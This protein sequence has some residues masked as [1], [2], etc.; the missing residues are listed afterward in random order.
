[1]KEIVYMPLEHIEQRY[2]THLDNDI[3]NYLS[4][5]HINW[6]YLHPR[7]LGEDQY[8]TIKNGNFLNANDTIYRQFSQFQQLIQGLMLG[9]ISKDAT[10]FITDIWNFGIMAIPY[11]NFF[12]EYDLKVKGV[13]HAGSFTDTDFVRQMERYYKNF[14]DIIFD[15]CDTI[16]V[17]SEFIKQDII[18]KRVID[19]DKLVVTGLPL[20]ENKY[21]RYNSPIKHDNIIFNGRNCDEKQPWLF[22]RLQEKLPNYNFF[23]TQKMNLKKH[24]YYTL[25]N[26]SKAV[27]SF[28]LQENFG[29]GIQEAVQLGCIPIV[30]NRLVYPE[31]FNHLY[32]YD[33]FDECVKKVDQAIKGVLSVP[34][35]KN[36]TNK[37]IFKIWFNDND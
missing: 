25:L 3:C 11:L 35:L 27:V 16:Y 34:K 6:K 10:I 13:L 19:A 36:K 33:N 5:N 1:M 22:D 23:N 26:S 32:L 30:P 12:S 29:Y 28:A 2:T 15:I 24:Q 17:G 4:V 20:D 37:E 8:G 14:E 18:R 9:D 7:T 21:S 31:Q